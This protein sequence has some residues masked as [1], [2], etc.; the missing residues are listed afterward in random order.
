MFV[1]V[2]QSGKG[3]SAST[4]ILYKGTCLSPSKGVPG[5]RPDHQSQVTQEKAKGAESDGVVGRGS[6]IRVA[7]HILGK[8]QGPGV[9][10]S[11]LTVTTI[12]EIAENYCLLKSCIFSPHKKQSVPFFL[13]VELLYLVML[14]FA[15]YIERKCI[16]LNVF[17]YSYSQ[18][19]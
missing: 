4:E 11:T 16:R 3:D 10:A 15:L 1:R 12:D 7:R 5:V 6:E 14:I 13:F 2:R 17:M 19:I 9:A 18:I 8:A